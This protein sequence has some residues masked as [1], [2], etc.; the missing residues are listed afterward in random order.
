MTWPRSISVCAFLA[1]PA[2]LVPALAAGCSTGD[3]GRDGFTPPPSPT[4]PFEPTS[5]DKFTC[6]ADQLSVV[7][8][9]GKA[10]ACD[11][12]LGC[13]NGACVPACEAAKTLQSTIGCEY[14]P[15][16]PGVAAPAQGSCYAIM[17]AN[18][19]NTPVSFELSWGD[20]K[21]S[22][23]YIRIPRGSGK[24][25]TYDL[26]PD[27]KLPPG[28]L[29]VAFLSSRKPALDPEWQGT[30][31][32]DD[33]GSAVNEQAWVTSGGRGKAFH[34]TSSAPVIAYDIYP[35]GGAS[36]FF[37]SSS[38]LLPT[39]A[40]GKNYIAVDGYEASGRMTGN[41]FFPYMQVIATEAD[42]TVN[43][44]PKI[45]LE[46]GPNLPNAPA[47]AVYTTKLARGEF[48]QFTQKDELNG[49][50]VESDKPVAVVGGNQC[51]DIPTDKIAC[52]TIHQQLP[53]IG[54]M[55]DAY[56]ATRYRDRKSSN[57]TNFE[58]VPWRITGVEDGTEL[59]YE[60]DQPN[61]PKTIGRGQTLEFKAPGPFVIRTQDKKHPVYVAS[62]MTAGDEAQ[63]LKSA[64]EF[65]MSGH[66]DPEFVNVTP[67]DQY[68]TNYVFLTDPTFGNTNLVFVRSTK[69]GAKDVTLDCIG[70]VTG[71][72]KVGTSDFEMARVDLQFRGQPVGECTN[73]VHR[74]KSDAPFGLTVWGFDDYASYGFA[75][76]MAAKPL[77]D[78]RVPAVVR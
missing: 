59:R 42:T 50:I 55:G 9:D 46:G 26:L 32:P 11:P 16:V 52:D 35:Y 57:D 5:C 17:L 13:L 68:L 6:S 20:Q 19:W 2:I 12:G 76:G 75:A 30:A 67:L 38:L 25:L 8:C 7:D 66:G 74:A 48:L 15:A 24:G 1:V 51:A 45:L 53:S 39:L 40:W 3:D 36:T 63:Y 58:I 23:S 71:W 49:T 73:G 78:V 21:L 28:E 22:T 62:Y 47:N 77:N 34:L 41:G 18:V 65:D 61:A 54:L 37:P 60:P 64:N 70:P 44:V 33:V 72:Q 69:D 4:T 29:A 31:C 10:K 43:L 14:F 27:G 56:V